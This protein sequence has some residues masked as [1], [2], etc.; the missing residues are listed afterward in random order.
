MQLINIDLADVEQQPH[1]VDETTRSGLHE[2]D[3]VNLVH[4]IDVGCWVR[5]T[6]CGNYEA[7]G[8]SG[9]YEARGANGGKYKAQMVIFHILATVNRFSWISWKEESH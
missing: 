2:R 9:D 7:R 8:A 5:Y 4:G 6:H 1:G 3:D